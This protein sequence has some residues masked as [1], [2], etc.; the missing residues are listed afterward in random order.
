MSDWAS[1]VELRSFSAS[2]SW[3]KS[4]WATFIK[5]MFPDTERSQN[6]FPAAKERAFGLI[7]ILAASD[8]YRA[9][10][11]L[12]CRPKGNPTGMRFHAVPAVAIVLAATTSFAQSI[13]LT[14]ASPTPTPAA[15][16]SSPTVAG[17]IVRLDTKAKTFAVKPFGSGKPVQFTAGDEVDVHQL[18]RGERVVVTYAAGIATRVQATRSGR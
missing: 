1:P 15:A 7:G 5:P 9:N 17:R 11:L 3:T 6:Q 12:R 16:S 18:R 4:A 10:S 14:I 8:D 13:P 2:A